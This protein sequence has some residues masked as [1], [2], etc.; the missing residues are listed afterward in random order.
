MDDNILDLQKKVA[1][2]ATVARAN[3]RKAQVRNNRPVTFPVWPEAVRSAPNAILRS[4]LFGVVRKGKR[5]N[6]DGAALVPSVKGVVIEIKRGESLDQNDLEIWEEVVHLAR[7]AEP[8][9][10]LEVPVRQL[11]EALGRQPGK[12]N[13][14]WAY[15]S[16]RRLYSCEI[17]VVMEKEG[18]EFEGPLI[19][20][21]VIETGKPI[22][23]QLDPGLAVLWEPGW[24]RQNQ[25]QRHAL[26][27]NQLAKWLHAFYGTHKRPHPYKV[28]TLR[29]L[30]GSRTKEL[31][32]F[33]QQLKTA[34]VLVNHATGWQVILDENDLLHVIKHG[35]KAVDN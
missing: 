17:K 24:T 26:G 21:L 23:L 12:P 19:Q 20:R 22:A 32:K 10:R 15:D 33:R 30:C 31:K 4:A 13:R 28:E 9:S 35:P 25:Q 14:Q 1:R 3:K 11:L 18:I 16:L 29:D 2:L 7:Q 5:T 34:A 8:G 27:Q 6:R